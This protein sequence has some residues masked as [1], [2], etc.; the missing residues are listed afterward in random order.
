MTI[1]IVKVVVRIM[2]NRQYDQESRVTINS[3]GFDIALVSGD[4]LCH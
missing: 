4:N 2:L 1:V 3:I